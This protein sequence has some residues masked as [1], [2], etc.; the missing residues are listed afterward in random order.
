M[1]LI[2]VLAIFIILVIGCF[3]AYNIIFVNNQSKYGDRLDGIE[4]VKIT[5]DIKNSI[6]ENIATLEI[7]KNSSVRVSGKIINV[8]ATLNDDIEVGKAKEIADKVLEKLS[9]D[10]KAFYDV[11]VFIKKDT[12]DEKFPIVGYKHHSRENITW[13]KDR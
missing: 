6:K 2:I 8:T 3:V 4:K 1:R 13:T 12:D 11:Q 7:T 9:D 5:D 10:E